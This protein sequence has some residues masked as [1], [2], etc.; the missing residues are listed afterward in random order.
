MLYFRYK[1]VV[2]CT[3]GE[4]KSQDVYSTLKCFWDPYR[5]NYAIARYDNY[6]IYAY[7]ICFGLYYD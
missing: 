6:S 4:K 7:A 5:D 2:I 1:I 3:V